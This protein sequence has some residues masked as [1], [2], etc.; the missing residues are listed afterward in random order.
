MCLSQISSALFYLCNATFHATIN[1]AMLNVGF[2]Y[3]LVPAS[4]LRDHVIHL[5]LL[6][7]VPYTYRDASLGA[8]TYNLTV[9]DCLHGIH[10]VGLR[11]L[12]T[13]CVIAV[14][15]IDTNYAMLAYLTKVSMYMYLL[16]LCDLI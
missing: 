13:L 1:F 4:L 10:K 15:Y 12:T 16:C 14:Y 11:K 9:L 2:E 6:L 7:H 5:H 8:S 3:V